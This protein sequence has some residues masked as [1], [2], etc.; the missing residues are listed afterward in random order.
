MRLSLEQKF[1]YRLGTSMFLIFNSTFAYAN[2]IS[3]LSVEGIGVG[4]SLLEFMSEK[5]IIKEAELTKNHY[6]YLE[7]PLKYSEVYIRKDFPVYDFVSVFFKRNN[8]NKYFKIKKQ[9]EIEAVRGQISFIEDFNGCL[10]KKNEVKNEVIS[11]FPGTIKSEDTFS[12]AL[13]PTGRS[14]VKSTE[15]RFDS[16]DLILLQCNDWEE[17]FRLDNNYSEGFK[18]VILKKEVDEWISN[19]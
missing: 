7:E 6:Y 4:D 10:K 16:G 3:D 11:M 9:Y 5:K 14:V 8:K 18:F 2:Q 19:Y 17:S 12:H 13:D 15:F 1:F